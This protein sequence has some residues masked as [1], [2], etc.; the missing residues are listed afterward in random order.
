MSE[1]LVPAGFE[2][3]TV[4]VGDP[5]ERDTATCVRFFHGM[6]ELAPDIQAQCKGVK[7]ADPILCE[8]GKYTKL[9]PFRFHVLDFRRLWVEREQGKQALNV[10][11]ENPGDK[12]YKEEIHAVILVYVGDR[13]VP[14]TCVFKSGLCKG[15]IPAINDLLGMRDGAFMSDWARRTP[16]HTVAAGIALPFARFV[17]EMT[18]K[19]STSKSSGYKYFDSQSSLPPTNAGDYSVL[20]QALE[21]EK[22]A[23]AKVQGNFDA[24]VEDLMKL[25]A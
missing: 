4:P 22:D 23:V 16:E 14:A 3:Y 24:R 21:S 10:A 13:V 12:A 11:T 20:G 2:R 17:V 25:A 18:T 5:I 1:A 6:S 15:V 7:P 8:N 19:Q 9:D